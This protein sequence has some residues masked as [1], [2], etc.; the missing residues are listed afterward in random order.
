MR[1]VY[2]VLRF[3]P[4]PG[5][6]E[7]V[8]IGVIV[9]SDE[10]SEWE[11]RLVDNPRRARQLDERGILPKVWD[12]VN[13]V[14][15]RLDYFTDA[16]EARS[17]FPEEISEKWLEALWQQS[18]NVVQL[19]RPAPISE[20]SLERAMEFLFREMIV[21]P[22]R[23]RYPFKKKNV[24]LAAVRRAY[25]EQGLTLG[26]NFFE[27]PTVHSPNHSERFD[28]AVANGMALQLT[29]TWSFQ[30][31]D[32]EKLAEDIKAWAWTVR[33]IRDGGGHA[34]TKD[35][36]RIEVPKDV[37]VVVVYVP[38]ASEKEEVALREANSAF[39]RIDVQA[40]PMERAS[41]VG[42]D[43]RDLLGPAL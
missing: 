28:F 39:R 3:V 19:S 24:A 15:Q 22:E 20:E 17:K 10:S 12:F 23:V 41:R 6:G 16:I 21:D 18:E 32:R 1:Y 25:R 29:Q 42:G 26:R 37:S 4:D 36:R 14:G 2:S 31:P 35:E 13:E 38:P 27:T 8:N 7:F 34:S 5:R 33:D 43:A 11:L 30:V 40:V 9:G